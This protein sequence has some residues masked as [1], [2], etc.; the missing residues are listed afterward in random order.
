MNAQ[1]E[2]VEHVELMFQAWRKQGRA[3]QVGGNM[4]SAKTD[5]RGS[6]RQS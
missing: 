2:A 6:H 5:L 1:V 3:G 4:I